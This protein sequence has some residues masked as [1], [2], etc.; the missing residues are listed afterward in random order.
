MFSHLRFHRLAAFVV[1]IGAALWVGTGDF[2]SVGSAQSTS[3]TSGTPAKSEPATEES[4]LRTVAAVTPVFVEHA[5]EIRVSGSTQPDKQAVLA[6][7]ASGII[8]MISIKQGQIVKAGSLVMSLEGPE[9]SASITNAETRLAQVKRTAGVTEKL[10]A[11]GNTSETKLVSDRTAVASAKAALSQANAAADRLN[12]T[13]PFGGFV[14]NVRVEQGEWLQ[15]GTPVATILSLDPIV[16]QAE[17]SELDIGY[18]SVGDK[19]EVNLV[20]GKKLQ[21]TVRFIALNASPATRTFKVEVALPNPDFG[22]PSGMTADIRLYAAPVR[23]VVVPRSVITLSDAG[24]L[25]LRVVNK[26]NIASF[27]AVE[28]I[29]DTPAGLVLA[30]VPQGMRIVVA[31]QDLVKDG[32]KVLVKQATSGLIGEIKQ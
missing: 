2:A 23:S 18:L 4:I 26:D 14:D 10:F 13:V 17:I 21:G 3:D 28:L 1:L 30:G 5:R 29:D 7:R 25:G 22:I 27:A 8:N 24:D 32:D 19:A 11:S 9:L 15:A 31:G 12:L 20:N 6:A 16:V